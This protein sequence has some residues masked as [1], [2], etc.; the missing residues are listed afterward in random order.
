VIFDWAQVLIDGV[1]EVALAD[2]SDIWRIILV[3]K[4]KIVL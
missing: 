4:Q 3:S 2:V 1:S